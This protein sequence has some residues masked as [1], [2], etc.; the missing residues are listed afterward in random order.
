M[1]SPGRYLGQNPVEMGSAYSLSQICC[2]VGTIHSE[3]LLVMTYRA[4]TYRAMTY[5]ARCS[6]GDIDCQLENMETCTCYVELALGCQAWPIHPGCST[7]DL[8]QGPRRLGLKG[9]KEYVIDIMNTDELVNEEDLQVKH[10]EKRIE[11]EKAEASS[12]L[13]KMQGKSDSMRALIGA[14]RVATALIVL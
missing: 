3:A 8:K 10:S 2:K 4:M 6:T 13:S 12:L 1:L 7:H 9:Q 5:R 11:E 14:T